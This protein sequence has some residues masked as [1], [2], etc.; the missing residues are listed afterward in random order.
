MCCGTTPAKAKRANRPVEQTKEG[1]LASLVHDFTCTLVL[2]EF[3]LLHTCWCGFSNAPFCGKSRCC[4][5]ATQRQAHKSVCAPL[6]HHIAFVFSKPRRAYLVRNRNNKLFTQSSV[7]AARRNTNKRL[8]ATKT[9]GSVP[10]FT[11][12]ANRPRPALR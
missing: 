3:F 4:L 1:L 6:S 11:R 9:S 7:S 10:A 12:A 8:D 5:V 2:D